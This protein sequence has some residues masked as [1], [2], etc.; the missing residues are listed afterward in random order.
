[1]CTKRGQPGKK[2]FLPSGGSVGATVVVVGSDG[3][4]SGGSKLQD[5]VC[6][7]TNSSIA[8]NPT[9]LAPLTALI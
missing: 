1:M 9:L 6:K 3:N 5:S 4:A 7:N 8:V 2:L